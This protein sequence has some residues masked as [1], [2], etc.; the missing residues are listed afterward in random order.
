[1][2]PDC[3]GDTC[4]EVAF[5]QTDERYGAL[6]ALLE[7]AQRGDYCVSCVAGFHLTQ[8][9]FQEQQT[10]S[11]KQLGFCDFC[12]LQHFGF[13]RSIKMMDGPFS[14]KSLQNK[15]ILLTTNFTLR[16]NVS[17]LFFQAGL[18][19]MTEWIPLRISDWTLPMKEWGLTLWR[20]GDLQSPPVTWDFLIL[21]AY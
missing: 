19:G 4:H 21:R 7:E 17:L 14:S 11:F 16:K 13:T 10:L 3:S 9:D 1:M 5:G 6:L 15:K 20:S 2:A 12:S 18:Q 8:R